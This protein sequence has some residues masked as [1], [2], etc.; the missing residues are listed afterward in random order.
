MDHRV[1]VL[2]HSTREPAYV[3]FDD[4]DVVLDRGDGLAAPV[5]PVEQSDV[6]T[7]LEK[8]GQE[9]RADVAGSAGHQDSIR[10]PDSST[11]P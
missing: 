2:K 9:H 11:G 3:P 1:D 7:S 8:H 4:L 5:E 10:H 6:V